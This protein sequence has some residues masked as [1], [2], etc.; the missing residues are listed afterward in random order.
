MTEPSVLFTCHVPKVGFRWLE[1]HPIPPP[2]QSRAWFLTVGREPGMRIG[3]GQTHNPLEEHTG[4]FRVFAD[5]EP[6]R[7]GIK[8]FAERF[9]SLGGDT[10]TWVAVYD[11][12]RNGGYA[13]AWSEAYTVWRDQ[14]VD[15]R[16]TV[17]LWDAARRGEVQELERKICWTKDYGSVGYRTHPGLTPSERMELREGSF[18]TLI[19]EKGDGI[20]ERFVPG[21]LVQPALFF[22]QRLV[23][24]RLRTRVSPRLLWDEQETQLRLHLVPEGLVGALWLQFAS[25]IEKDSEFRR[26]AECD[27]WFELAPGTARSDKLYCSNA[28]RTKAYRRRRAEAVRLHAE[29]RPIA[30]IAEQ[31][32]ADV[33]SVRGWVKPQQGPDES[34]GDEDA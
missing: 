27:I 8:E 13:G 31:V 4:L 29:G 5:T 3:G 21:D 32:Q 24:Q 30:E 23:N 22:V 2:H 26:C 16:R 7:D 28:C 1:T 33:E 11:E 9:G 10:R 12:P 34:G 20:L 6:S 25:A 17:D 14:I 15:M 19:A 18:S